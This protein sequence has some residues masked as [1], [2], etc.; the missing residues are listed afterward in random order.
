MRPEDVDERSAIDLLEREGFTV[1]ADA[2]SA[3]AVPGSAW[4]VFS[5]DSR[6]YGGNAGYGDVLGVQ[7]VYDSKVPNHRRVR[8][9]D[10]V[11]VRNNVEVHGVGRI[12]R[13]EKTPG[14]RKEQLVCPACGSG[15]FDAR[16]KQR[17][18]YRC[19]TDSCRHEFEQPAETSIEVDRFTAFLGGTWRP[20]DGALAPEELKSALL[21]RADQNAI[22]PIDSQRLEQMLGRLLVEV[23]P[24]PPNEEVGST[25]TPRGGR[26]EAV[27][28]ARNGQAGFRTE[29]LRRYGARCAITGPC[30]VEVLQAAHLKPFAEHETHVFDEGMLLRAD[31]HLLFDNELLA[32]DPDSWCVVVA[33]AL[34]AYPDY[35]RLAG[36]RLVEGP[37]PAAVREHYDAV[38]ATWG[39]ARVAAEQ[40]GSA[41]SG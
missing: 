20:L 22:R 27:T 10:V 2:I 5:S 36:V 41:Q 23:P 32:V 12:Q 6:K 34:D 31:V 25:R 40:V 7:Y 14:V 28:K 4:A 37:S 26:R 15:R 19:R 38:T 24:L 30:P 11:V 39:W 17:P 29:L 13:I 35:S 18:P 9:G 1:E 33:P 16:K 21:D 3:A 8:R